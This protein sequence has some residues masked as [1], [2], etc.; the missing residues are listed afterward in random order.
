MPESLCIS[1][2]EKAKERQGTSGRIVV[3]DVRNRGSGDAGRAKDAQETFTSALLEVPCE[4]KHRNPLEWVLSLV[5][6]VA[7]IVGLV[8]LPLFF[9]SVPNL[10][11]F[12]STWLVAPAPP[13]P[14]PPP[15]APIQRV[16]V[17]SVSRLLQNGRLTMPTAIPKKVM[18][19]KEAP[20]PPDTE[21]IGVVG[22]VPDGIAGGQASGV[23][24][25]IIGS[26]A[27]ATSI[28]PPPPPEKRIIRIGGNLKPPRLIY[29]PQPQ[30]PVIAK[31]AQIQGTVVIDAVID[32][33]GNV[34]Q[35]H[36]LSGPPLLIPA[37]LQTVIQWKYQPTYL[38][39][40]AISVA[41]HLDVHFVL[42]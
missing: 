25:G 19:L 36:A 37:A 28:A 22:G 16:L 21:A 14:P 32:E 15:A 27:G 42:Q 34:V 4:Y 8:I 18:I 17:K 24:G 2:E 3:P 23:L 12:Q 26:T 35:A 20:L 40:E 9:G 29:G 41:M 38:N 13:P 39:G 31:Q 10:K 6:H 33:H 30:Y 5:F 11:A 7:L 1:K